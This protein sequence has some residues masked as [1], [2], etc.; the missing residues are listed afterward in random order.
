[1][2]DDKY[3]LIGLNE[4]IAQLK[5]Y[6]KDALRDLRKVFNS[7]MRKLLTESQQLVIKASNHGTGAP[8]SGWRTSPPKKPHESV[9]GGRGWPHWDAG[10]VAAAISIT[11]GQGKV[12]GDYTTTAYGLKN[13]SAAGVIFEAAG[14][15]GGRSTVSDKRGSGEQFKRTL[16]AR[17]G[18][19]RRLVYKVA[20]KNRTELENKVSVAMDKAN[21]ALQKALET[22]SV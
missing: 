20:F 4:T 18:K 17:Y 12:R 1:M 10:E 5:K 19:A 11:R 7:E 6:D 22:K 9:R 3:I 2:A 21:E 15:K 16:S 8:M 14:R 13:A